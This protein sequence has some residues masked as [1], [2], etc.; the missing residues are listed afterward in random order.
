M[1]N[2]AEVGIDVSKDVLDV[3]VPREGEQRETARFDNEAG[4]HEKLVRGLTKR[5][6]TARVDW[7]RRAP[8]AWT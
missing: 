4:G 7:R 3:A 8:T 1:S 5:G 6:D 2:R